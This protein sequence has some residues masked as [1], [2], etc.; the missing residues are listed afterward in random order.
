MY[1]RGSKW[2]MNRRRRRIHPW[3]ILILIAL[4]GAAVYVNQVVVPATPPLFIP[5]ATPTR[6][7]A[8]YITDAEAAF[9]EG[10]LSAAIDAYREAIR[11]NPNDPAIYVALA[12][13]EIY[14]G[15]YKD[16]QD[17]AENALLLN[18]NNPNA[19]ALR[20]WALTF[21]QD[22]LPAEASI[23]K[24]IELDPNNVWAHAFYAELIADQ[25]ANGTAALGA[26]E[27][28][29]SESNIALGLD[30][31]SLEAHR[32]R[33]IVLQVTGNYEEAIQQFEAAAQI[34]NH[35][36]DIHMALGD[37]YRY[38]K[39]PQYDKAIDEYTQASLLRPDDPVAYAA[40]SRTYATT[41]DYAK[42]IQYAQQAVAVDP[43]NPYYWGNLGQMYYRTGKYE[44][45]IN[46]L[47]L[48][49]RGGNAP[50]GT[51]VQG[52]P[53]DSVLVAGY[54]SSFGLAL[55]KNNQCSEAI[56]VSQ[57]LL[58]AMKDDETVAYNANAIV[59]IC[60]Q[61]IIGTYT[62][63]PAPRGTPKPPA[64]SS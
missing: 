43:G 57:L 50:N 38:L 13:V 24:A 49:V 51:P 53:L 48:A 40:I 4:V 27:K 20:G 31:N 19:L 55:A 3:R 22:Y 35:I 9:N 8:S 15:K 47:R 5:T 32:A 28:A 46:A 23:K 25:I 33:G 11:S 18:P 41:G 44:D 29:A 39:D 12:R 2:S 7:P 30:A 6:N 52:L 56:Q 36:A 17:D 61:N 42:S 64:S 21:Q 34:N 59:D 60:K 45:A 54:Y 1:L 26:P 14:A 37:S 62:P 58:Q 63:T 16:A 10:K